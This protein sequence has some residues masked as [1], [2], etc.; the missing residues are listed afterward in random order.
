MLTDFERK[1]VVQIWEYGTLNSQKEVDS[2]AMSLLETGSVWNLP[3]EYMQLVE[4]ILEDMRYS[5]E[6][7]GKEN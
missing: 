2:F 1:C 4:Y 7:D 3:K 5:G 6:L